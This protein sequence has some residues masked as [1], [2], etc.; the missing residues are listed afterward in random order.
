MKVRTS[1]RFAAILHGQAK[2]YENY[3]LRHI[4][5]VDAKEEARQLAKDLERYLLMA[6]D[7][8]E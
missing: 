3:K 2:Y 1:K 4:A 7:E 8:S 5:H 6:A